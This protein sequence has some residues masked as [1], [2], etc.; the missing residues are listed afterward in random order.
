[1]RAV[2]VG[3]GHVGALP[4]VAG[5]AGQQPDN[6]VSQQKYGLDFFCL[7]D[8][9]CYVMRIILHEHGSYRLW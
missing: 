2:G 7:F 6:Y 9:F 5:R 4:D 8:A 1:M 3:V